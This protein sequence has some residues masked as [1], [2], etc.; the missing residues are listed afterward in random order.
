MAVVEKQKFKLTKKS[1]RAIQK[2]S[3]DI[4]FKRIE[5]CYKEISW[6][7]REDYFRLRIQCSYRDDWGNHKISKRSPMLFDAL[8]L[9]ADQIKIPKNIRRTDHKEV[10]Y[11]SDGYETYHAIFFEKGF[12]DEYDAKSFGK[13]YV[14]WEALKKA[15]SYFQ[16]IEQ[17]IDRECF[18]IDKDIES[19]ERTLKLVHCK[20]TESFLK[21]KKKERERIMRRMR[22]EGFDKFINAD[23]PNN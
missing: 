20:K 1:I 12:R 9:F 15:L 6:R 11:G 14:Q 22:R 4:P 21:K 18:D 8:V 3:F 23:E 5:G 17:K 2:L 10:W 13:I 7:D 16:E 19:L